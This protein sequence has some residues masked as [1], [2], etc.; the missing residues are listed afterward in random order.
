MSLSIQGSGLAGTS[1]IGLQNLSVST[2]S[3]NADSKKEEEES[4]ATA[5]SADGDTLEISALGTAY[6]QKTFVGSSGEVTSEDE[7]YTDSTAAMISEAASGVGIN[8]YT[9]VQNENSADAST[10]SSSSYSSSTSS[11]SSYTTLELKQMLENGEITQAEYN[12]EIAS[13]QSG[14][15]EEEE[16]TQEQEADA[17]VEE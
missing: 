17:A 16:E 1:A 7:G 10:V 6:E 9:S 8:E 3:V 14:E 13:R 12:E 5:V 2:S 15:T 11:L 4:S